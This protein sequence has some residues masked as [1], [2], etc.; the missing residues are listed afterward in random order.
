MGEEKDSLEEMLGA[1]FT[2][3]YTWQAQN[4]DTLYKK[5]RGQLP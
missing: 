4:R 2:I 5:T 3:S 1:K